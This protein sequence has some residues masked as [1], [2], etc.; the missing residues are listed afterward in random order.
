MNCQHLGIYGIYQISQLVICQTTAITF[1]FRF[2]GHLRFR[3]FRTGTCQVFAVHSP[4]VTDFDLFMYRN[5]P[6]KGFKSPLIVQPRAS[7]EEHKEN[8]VSAC[9]ERVPSD[10]VRKPFRSNLQILNLFEKVTQDDK[11]ECDIVQEKTNPPKKR[12]AS[13]PVRE[14]ETSVDSAQTATKM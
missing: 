4:C 8:E 12:D 7:V 9:R 2:F 1:R 3:A 5:R 13:S 6:V 14:K 10:L 11:V